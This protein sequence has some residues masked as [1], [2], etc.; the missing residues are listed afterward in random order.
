VQLRTTCMLH[1]VL[2]QPARSAAAHWSVH[3]SKLTSSDVRQAGP[4]SLDG[5]MPPTPRA[6]T[7]KHASPWPCDHSSARSS[8]GVDADASPRA[9][10]PAHYARQ[11]HHAHH[12]HLQ[13]LPRGYRDD[14]RQESDDESEPAPPDIEAFVSV[15]VRVLEGIDDGESDG[16][17]DHDGSGWGEACGG[18][19]L[20]G[21]AR[22][23]PWL[24]SACMRA[25][26]SRLTQRTEIVC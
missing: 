2:T 24:R 18:A 22:I 26:T 23:R 11:A 16:H 20:D 4:N 7:A 3:A 1:V 21:P 13:P 14:E 15:G 9:A 5:G 25:H 12:V 10:P 6:A 19:R 17:H 8:A